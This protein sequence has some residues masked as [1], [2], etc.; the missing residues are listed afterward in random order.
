MALLTYTLLTDPAPLEASR[1]GRPPSKGTVYLVVTNTGQAAA[2][3]STIKV[4]VPVGNGA[5]DLTSDFN[6]IK[7]KGE[8]GTRSG[9]RSP[10]NVQPG[11]QGS[12]AFQATAPGGRTPLAPGDHMVLT[13]ENVTV[14]PKSGLAVLQVTENAG[15]TKT[16][17]LSSGFAAVALVKTAPKEIPA[18]HNFLADNAV[19]DAGTKVT[20]SWEGSDDFTYEILFPGGRKPVP[21]VKHTGAHGPYSV[22]LDAADAPKRDTAYTLIASSGTQRHTFTTIVQV[23]NPILDTLTAVNG[24]TTPWVQGATKGDGALTFSQGA[25]HVRREFGSQEGGALHTGEA[26]VSGIATGEVTADRITV[27]RVN[28]ER[29]QGKAN[30][31][32]LTF[33]A[34]GVEVSNNSGGQGA[35]LADRIA[36]NRVNTERVQGKSTGDGWITFP[37]GGIQV[38]CGAYYDTPRLGYVFAQTICLNQSFSGEEENRWIDL[39]DGGEVSVKHRGT[40]GMTSYGSL[41]VSR[42]DTDFHRW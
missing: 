27:N 32:S 6:K 31:G 39:S 9:T 25:M 12:N 36:V 23:R 8:Y 30:T 28:T 42:V 13:L 20:L 33:T 34:D 1:A 3:W 4:E 29:V 10:V 5:G 2:Y 15:R 14:A 26:T 37:Y 24:V 40:D 22:V 11:P 35:V 17:G 38:A 41:K 7:P 21:K 18:P 16:G 19:V